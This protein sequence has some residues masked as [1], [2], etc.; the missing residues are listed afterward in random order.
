MAGIVHPVRNRRGGKVFHDLVDAPGTGGQLHQQLEV[1]GASTVEGRQVVRALPV[2][3]AV[4]RAGAVG[5]RQPDPVG[6]SA[7]RPGAGHELRPLTVGE[8]RGHRI[9]EP[10][11]L[12]RLFAG[13]IGRGTDDGHRTRQQQCGS[14]CDQPQAELPDGRCD[15]VGIK[16]GEGDGCGRA[17]VRALGNLGLADGRVQR[18]IGNRSGCQVGEGQAQVAGDGDRPPGTVHLAGPGAYGDP[19]HRSRTVGRVAHGHPRQG[20]AHRLLDRTRRW[21][22]RGE[23]PE[24]LLEAGPGEELPT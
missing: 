22:A 6:A 23:P 16:T 14:G 15:I 2:D 10:Q 17:A 3:D 24:D 19:E 7:V 4:P 20:I 1:V 11:P 5:E 21:G 18:G 9:E 12:R 8:Q 13:G